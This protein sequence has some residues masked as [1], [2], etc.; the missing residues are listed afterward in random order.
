MIGAAA[1]DGQIPSRDGG[2]SEIVDFE[3]ETSESADADSLPFV[4]ELAI[5]C[6]GARNRSRAFTE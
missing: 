5:F 4:F 1:S 6:C 2:P 3:M